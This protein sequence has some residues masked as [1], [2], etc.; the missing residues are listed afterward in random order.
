MLVLISSEDNIEEEVEMVSS[1]FEGGYVFR[2][3]LRKPT[4]SK[5]ELKEIVCKIN[6]S[7]WEKCVVH[8][9]GRHYSFTDFNRDSDKVIPASIST[10]FHSEED[11]YDDGMNYTYFFCSPVFESI[12]KKGYMPSVDW[13]TEKWDRSL[14][15]KAVALG[16]INDSNLDAVLKK[17]FQNLAV[18]GHVWLSKDPKTSF[19]KLY[20]RCLQLDLIA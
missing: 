2:F 7:H 11:V 10:S 15:K 14:Q 13:N 5:A 4:L 17:G 1:L 20:E 16:G 18:V 8:F 6:E 9:Q 3:H 12:S 19:I